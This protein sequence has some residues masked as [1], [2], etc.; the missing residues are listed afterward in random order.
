MKVKN[1]SNVPCT[2][3]AEVQVAADV[4]EKGGS[5]LQA[6]LLVSKCRQVINKDEVSKSKCTVWWVALNL[7]VPLC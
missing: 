5:F 2:N 3:S 4:L 6:L 7:F 1:N